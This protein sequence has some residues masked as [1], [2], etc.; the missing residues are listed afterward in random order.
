MKKPYSLLIAA[1]LL[2]QPTLAAPTKRSPEQE[3]AV[4]ARRLKPIADEQWKLI[5]GNRLSEK[6]EIAKGDTLFDISKRLF[7]DAKYWPKIWALNNADITN[8]HRLKPGKLIAFLPGT[9]TSLPAVA[10]DGAATSNSGPAP[11]A[12]D[13]DGEPARSSEWR[14]LPKQR[15]EHVGISLPPEVDAQGFDKRNKVIFHTT[16]GYALEAI[17]ASEKIPSLGKVQGSRSESSMLGLGDLVYIH[18]EETLSIGQT[19]AITQDPAPLK[20]KGSDRSGYSYLS[21]G[22]VKILSVQS[23]VYVGTVI[24]SRSPISRGN[25]LMPVPERIPVL[26]PVPGPSALEAVLMLDRSISTATTAQYKQVFVDRGSE[27]G[28]RPG[29][30]FRAYE[31]RDPATQKEVTETDFIISADILVVQVSPQISSGI[32]L[33]SRGPITENTPLVLLTDVADLK[34]QKD[35]RERSPEEISQD[36]E[37]DDLDKSDPNNQLQE[38]EKKELQ[39]LESWEGN[40]SEAQ[41]VPASQEEPLAPPPEDAALDGP[42]P[43]DAELDAGPA[44]D[45]APPPTAEEPPPA[46][47]AVSDPDLDAPV[48]SAD[49]AIPAMEDMP[50]PPAP[51]E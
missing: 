32:V 19:Y 33:R 20:A 14:Q 15:W 30:I 24:S 47:D 17:A 10:F 50:P 22:I 2:S 42:G 9:G 48:P 40:P 29:M 36:N 1:S 18:A 28:L 49:D 12:A 34:K 26:E 41:A 5:A 25:M 8:P 3:S 44:P 4:L 23:G 51:E 7:G 11:A 13:P 6:Y 38:N 21:K 31:K 43:Q 37:L 46:P 45:T 35:F 39:Q 27:D 16:K